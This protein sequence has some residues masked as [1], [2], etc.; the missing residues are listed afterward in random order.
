MWD[1][2]LNCVDRLRGYATGKLLPAVLIVVLGVLI[3]KLLMR[4]ITSALKKTKIE[5]P[6]L[7]LISGV[8]RGVLYVLLAL[9]GASALGLDVT[10]ILAFG[11]LV[12]M[13]N[14]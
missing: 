1:F 8:L 13:E 4:I 3:I 12:M 10:G 9:V 5:A 11:S 2:I 7:S 6:V 14:P